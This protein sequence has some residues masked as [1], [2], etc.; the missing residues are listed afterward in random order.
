MNI[1]VTG[2]TGFIG[3]HL[4]RRLLEEKHQITCVVRKPADEKPFHGQVKIVTS[5]LRNLEDKGSMMVGIDVVI[6]LAA[7]LGHYGIP[8]EYYYEV[9]CRASVTLAKMSVQHGVKQFILCSAPFVVGLEGRNTKE[10]EPYAP[11]N[12]YAETKML[13]EKG[14]IEVCQGKIAYTILRP[15]FVYGVGD[16]RRTALYRSIKHRRFVL[17]TSGKSYLQPSY[18]TDIVEGFMISILNPRAYNEIFNIG[19]EKDCTA[20]EYLD[21]IAESVGTKLIHINI[22][23]GLSVFIANTIDG[24]YKFL[25]KKQ[26]FVTKGRIDFLAK[27]HS[28][29]ITK[30]KTMLGYSPKVSVAEGIERSVRWAEEQ[31]YLS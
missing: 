23:Y 24:I 11:S 26:A 25:F 27:D 8:Y 5:D 21:C 1:L 9:N 19:A 22:G 13:A 29:D 10:D 16:V 12:E 6:H 31:G 15:S 17:T 3:T 2:A 28:C 7:Q 18:I 4:V 20:K 30:A 14:V